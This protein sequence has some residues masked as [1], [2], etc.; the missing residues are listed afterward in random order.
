MHPDRAPRRK[1]KAAVV[2]AAAAIA[3]GATLRL[4]RHEIGTTRLVEPGPSSSAT[5]IPDRAHS[6][7][8]EPLPEQREKAG[9]L[10][11]RIGAGADEL[12]ALTSQTAAL[13]AAAAG[14]HKRAEGLAVEL[15]AARER[16]RA[17]DKNVAALSEEHTKLIESGAVA[18]EELQAV[19][20]RAAALSKAAASEQKRAEGLAV[21][22]V[23]ARRDAEA[24][25]SDATALT[26][27]RKKVEELA[28]QLSAVQ[29]H[30]QSV[31]SES[32]AMKD[33]AG[34]ERKRAEGLVVELAAA[35][36]A[37][38]AAEAARDAALLDSTHVAPEQA[39]RVEQLVRDLSDARHE[40]QRL[41]AAA[42][43][44]AQIAHA[45]RERAS[46]DRAHADDQAATLIEAAAQREERVQSLEREISAVQKS[47]VE[48]EARYAP[49]VQAAEKSRAE[50]ERLNKSIRE[51][52]E[53]ADAY[54]RE[55]DEAGS[56]VTALTT[57]LRSRA[58]TA[59]S[60]AGLLPSPVTPATGAP[61][62]TTGTPDQLLA[63]AASG[64]VVSVGER[65]QQPPSTANVIQA[66]RHNGPDPQELLQRGR[67]LLARGDV[68][69]GRLFLERASSMG[70][71]RAAFLLA[72]TYDPGRLEARRAFGL[73]GDAEQAR[74]LY[75]D[76][77][78]GGIAE[79]RQR[80]EAL[81]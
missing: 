25:E 43:E 4:T 46:R 8:A 68:S 61:E 32:A 9:E 47:V 1:L 44:F 49:V 67:A 22:L 28:E 57:Q 72:E 53:R 30:L 10:T 51:Q 27:E 63:T 69:G 65:A 58:P 56:Q 13:T 50:A 54:A 26:S 48:A 64:D 11:R 62:A 66:L 14:E 37:A 74:R 41:E 23:A 36:D 59:D 45:E 75:K 20:T 19:T 73:R 77:F 15:A 33:V 7:L 52:R 70:E 34:T 6:S 24:A 29:D 60:E 39:A 5:A 31:R 16:V 40:V 2:A 17:A 80:L 18:R 42:A 78:A 79:A 3:L 38:R 21:E 55:L 81:R 76:A 12:R 71:A 35:R